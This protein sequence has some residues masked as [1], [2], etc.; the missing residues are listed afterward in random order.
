MNTFVTSDLHFFHKNII[1]YCPESRLFESVE[2]MNE[3]IIRNWNEKVSSDDIVYILGDVSFG[4]AKETVQ[5]LKRLNGTKRL[6]IGN[7]DHKIIRSPVF[8]SMFDWVK[9]YNVEFFND[10]MV[11]MFHFPIESW[12]QKH[13][14][15]YHLHGHMHS[16]NSE[17]LPSRRYDCGLDGNACQLYNINELLDDIENRLSKEPK[18]CHH[19][20]EITG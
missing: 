15:S 11:V 18:F 13:R 12:D 3:S 1:K 5:I 7:H 19:G 10:K 20:R 8:C 9:L 17:T 14:G 16:K 6:V 4:P 2:D